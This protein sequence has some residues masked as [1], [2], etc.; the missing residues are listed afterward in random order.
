[1]CQLVAVSTPSQHSRLHAN[2]IVS[3]SKISPAKKTKKN[4]CD[5]QMFLKIQRKQIKCCFYCKVHLEGELLIEDGVEGLP[6]DLGLKFLLLVRQQ[7][8]LYVWVRCAT[9][10]HSR[11]L[12][13]LNDPHHELRRKRGQAES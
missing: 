3:G 12:G 2:W 10:V 8:D 1:M 11:Q 4:V 6:V 7:V 9:H 13:R 5:A